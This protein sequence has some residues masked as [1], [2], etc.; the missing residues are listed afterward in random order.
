METTSIISIILSILS[1]GV[2]LTTILKYFG[3]VKKAAQYK[4]AR[5]ASMEFELKSINMQLESLNSTNKEIKEDLSNFMI[6]TV[7]LEQFYKD[8]E[9]LGVADLPKTIGSLESSLKSAHKRIDNLE[10]KIK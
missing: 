3:A 5:N 4:G 6:R 9:M 10:H 1:C 7:K 2:A 8:A